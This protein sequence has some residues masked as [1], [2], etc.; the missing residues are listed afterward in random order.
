MLALEEAT[1]EKL[2]TCDSKSWDKALAALQAHPLGPMALDLVMRR[3]KDED[4]A[5]AFFAIIDN[6]KVIIAVAAI[7]HFWK[8][9]RRPVSDDD[10][11][12]ARHY[13]RKEDLSVAYEE[14]TDALRNEYGFRHD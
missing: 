9:S 2:K 5:R 14:P 11:G 7:R 8:K 1:I 3:I 13:P 12:N 4:V 10:W 6:F